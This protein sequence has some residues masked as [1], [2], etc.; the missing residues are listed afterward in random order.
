MDSF[1]KVQLE[2]ENLQLLLA[3]AEQVLAETEPKAPTVIQKKG[4]EVSGE[5]CADC[6]IEE[7]AGEAEMAS[8]FFY[9]WNRKS[10]PYNIIMLCL[11]Q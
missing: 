11:T 9:F 1:R 3:Q 2:K 7:D 5:E 6:G 8:P 10:P 4:E